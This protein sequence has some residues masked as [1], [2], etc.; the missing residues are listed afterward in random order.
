MD[1]I[2][3]QKKNYT[4][5]DVNPYISKKI[6]EQNQQIKMVLDAE[7]NFE[8]TSDIESLIAFWENIWANGGLLFEGSK[9][10]FRLPDLYIRQK[11]YD[12]ALKI[13]KQ[14]RSPAYL[15]KAASY[16][17]KIKKAKEKQREK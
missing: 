4:L 17:E 13:V 5:K 11:R 14:I 2:Q 3:K 1:K 16:A 9:W 8:R 10:T 7:K 15:D 12:D 6:E